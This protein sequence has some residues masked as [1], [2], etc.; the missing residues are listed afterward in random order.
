MSMDLILNKTA[1][2]NNFEIVTFQQ[3]NEEFVE[4]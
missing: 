3:E 1:R 4:K 2:T